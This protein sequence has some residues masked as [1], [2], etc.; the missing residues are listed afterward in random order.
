MKKSSVMMLFLL[1]GMVVFTACGSKMDKTAEE[2]KEKIIE[3]K[4]YISIDKED[5]FSFLIYKDNTTNRYIAEV[6]VPT[7][8]KSSA[9]KYYYYLDEKKHLKEGE[10]EKDFND[11]KNNGNYE[12]VYKSGKFK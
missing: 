4:N 1:L 2:F 6:L 3:E 12:V 8:E 9:V 11:T 10:S 7:K 5:T